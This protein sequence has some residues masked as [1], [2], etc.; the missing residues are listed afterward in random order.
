MLVNDVFEVPIKHPPWNEDGVD[1]WHVEPLPFVECP[2]PV[3]REDFH[4]GGLLDVRVVVHD[5]GEHVVP[6]HMPVFP[7]E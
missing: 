2:S 4:D 6:R 7:V 1:E 5:V 3:L